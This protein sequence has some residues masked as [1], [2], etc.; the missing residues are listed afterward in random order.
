MIYSL[1]KKFILA[2]MVSIMIVLTSIFTVM[3]IMGNLQLNHA[4]D[5]LT[6]AIAA[7]DGVFPQFEDIARRLPAGP[8]PHTDVITEETPFST[9]FLPCGLTAIT[10]P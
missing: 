6:D 1:R 5:E 2:S 7:N 9:R 4:M 10:E 3:F 8:F